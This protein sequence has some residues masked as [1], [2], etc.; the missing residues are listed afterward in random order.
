MKSKKR[1][2]LLFFLNFEN[3]NKYYVNL[4]KH[5]VSRSF[6]NKLK[7]NLLK[8]PFLSPAGRAN[9]NNPWDGNESSQIKTADEKQDLQ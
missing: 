5:V 8:T 1:A 6:I 2:K 9:I 7:R 4:Q 3:Q